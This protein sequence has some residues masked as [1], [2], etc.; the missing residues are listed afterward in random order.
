MSK[1][2]E[3]HILFA[4]RLVEEK[5]VEILIKTIEASCRDEYTRYHIIWHI[6]SRW[7]HETA[8]ES[9][10][11]RYP[12]RV[13]YYGGVSQ[14]WLAT[15]YRQADFLFMPSLF[16]ET[17][18]LTALESLACGTWVIGFQKGWLVSFIPDALSLD[19]RDPVGSFF[20]IIESSQGQDSLVD[21][22]S[23]TS[24]LW[25][26]SLR[27][28]FL[29]DS[30]IVLLHDYREK[31]GGAEYYA[32]QAEDALRQL[33]YTTSRYSYEWST[34]VWKRRWL[35]IFSLFTFWRYFL[36]LSF[37][38]KTSPTTIWMHSILR[39]MGHWWVRAV[40]RYIDESDAKVYLSHHDVWLLAP[41]PQSI[42]EEDQIPGDASLWAFVVGLSSMRQIFA[43]IKWWYIWLIKNLLPK[44]TTHIIFSPFLEKHI[45]AHFPGHAII[46]LPHSYDETV[47]HPD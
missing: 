9:L 29:K 17:F 16:L 33:E 36:V 43:C 46:V 32:W 20:S 26:W 45:W 19:R 3:L 30:S 5:W 39:Y 34:T 42:T 38:R 15:L 4:S 22:S 18:G 6:C 12:Q 44:N 37:L 23:Y 24:V 40:K 35:F 7:T 21:I 31:I 13:I 8:I 10:V 11:K 2:N 25:K 1:N 47:F 28:I 14:V 27:E 41:F